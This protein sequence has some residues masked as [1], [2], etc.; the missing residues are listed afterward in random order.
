LVEFGADETAELIDAEH[1]SPFFFAG[2][3]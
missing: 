3:I 1:R 2:I